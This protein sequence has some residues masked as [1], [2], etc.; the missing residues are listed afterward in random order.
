VSAAIS[1]TQPGLIEATAPPESR[2]LLRDEVRL[3]VT[4]RAGRSH[5]HAAFYD[6]SKFLHGGDLVVINDSATVPAAMPAHRENG[7]PIDLHVSTMIDERI[8]ITEPR[9][10]VLC[11]EELQL[12]D[13]GSAV[14]IA[15]VEP[16]RPRLWYTWF[17]LPQPMFDYL[18]ATGEP[19]RYRYMKQRFPLRD[20][21][22][23][24]AREPGSS[25]MPSAGRPFTP[26][27]VAALNAKGIEIA[28]LTLHCGVASFEAPERPGTERFIVPHATAE[29]VNAA[30]ARGGRVVA[31]GT[32]VVRAL[33]SAIEGDK[34]VAASGWTGLVIDEHHHIRGAD[35]MLT[36][37][38]D[39]NATHVSILRAFLDRA[40]LDSAYDEAADEQ[41][42]YHEFG[43]VHLIL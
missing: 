16:E 30:R 7:A 20:Y 6:F 37:F 24:F 4:D 21:Q 12:P 32:T 2:G 5:T 35:G 3:L 23:M 8:W 17:Q 27:V 40:L 9:G 11:G 33:E 41:Y 42:R 1:Q 28:A 19:I 26:R 36:G 39:A 15:P 10:T 29:R 14:T 25:E 31:V 13:G 22:T 43:D 34:I 38:H 18:A